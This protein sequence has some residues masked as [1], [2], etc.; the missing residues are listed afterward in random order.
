MKVQL[1]DLKT[2]YEEL[3]EE[4][5]Q[6]LLDFLKGQYFILGPTVESFEKEVAQYCGVEHAIGVSSGSD[7]LLVALM[8]LGIG[9]GDEVVTSSYT[10][11]ATAGAIHRV[12]AKPVFADIEP[13]SFNVCPDSLEAAITDKTKA[14]I[15]VHLYGQSAEMQK[16][17][18]IA[19][20][21]G[22]PVIE[23]A[24][25][26]M[27]AEFEGRKVG[28][29][30]LMG[31]LSFFPSK[32]LGGFGDG[33][34][35]LTNDA[36]LADKL[37]VLR[38]HG[39]KPK[40]HHHLVGGNFRLDAIQAFILSKKL[41]HLDGWLRARRNVAAT[42]DRLFNENGLVE[43]GK[44][45]LPKEVVNG[46]TFNQYVVRVPDRDELQGFLKDK[47]IATAIYYPVPLH[48]QECFAELGYKKGDL[49][50]SERAAEETLALPICPAIEEEAQEY[51]V[52]AIEEFV[53]S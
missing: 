27:G 7:A 35:V 33:G 34:M 28:G 38:G 5:E 6:T 48:L 13:E 50:E 12:G 43:S 1:V 26:A 40:Y 37:K 16:I 51:V 47:D 30:G 25:Q 46:H 32:N 18:A 3:R 44:V 8:A 17:L 39:A 19:E 2:Q 15:P 10:F 42:Y 20:A 23:D 4:I 53:G 21:R 22:L 9:A 11:F 52:K 24:A 41:P 36:D 29:I 14:F 45:A 31:C 49:P